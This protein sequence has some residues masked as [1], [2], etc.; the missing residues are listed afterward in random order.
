VLLVLL[1]CP[2]GLQLWAE[3]EEEMLAHW[4]LLELEVE[5]AAMIGMSKRG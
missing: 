2:E 4:A 3:Q 1:V 5:P